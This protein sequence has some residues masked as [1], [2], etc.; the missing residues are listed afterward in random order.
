MVPVT[1]FFAGLLAFIYLALS[2]NVI[3]KRYTIRVTLGDGG[4]HN[5]TR[6]IRAHANFAEYVPMT[7]ILM[8]VNELNGTSRTFLIVMGIILCAA[9][10]SHALSILLVEARVQKKIIFRQVGMVWTFAV[11][12]LLAIKAML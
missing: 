2:V 9:R 11:I 6:R 7:L 8:T 3:V 12:V 5:M 1:A 4:N 10:F